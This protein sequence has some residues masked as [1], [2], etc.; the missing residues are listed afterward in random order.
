M[1]LSGA[2]YRDTKGGKLL[3]KASE[4]VVV[5]FTFSHV[6]EAMNLGFG[7]SLPEDVF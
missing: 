3:P 7:N 2:G 1:L 5:G 4:D 6:P